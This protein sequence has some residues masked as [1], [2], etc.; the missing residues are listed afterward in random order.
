ME[1]AG[2]CGV[3]IYFTYELAFSP[4]NASA[5]NI[6]VGHFKYLFTVVVSLTNEPILQKK[7]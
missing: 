2:I 1:W 5:S 7:K 3:N 6:T 4:C